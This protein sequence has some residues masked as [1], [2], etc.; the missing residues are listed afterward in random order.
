MKTIKAGE[1][2]YNT[3]GELP[4]S[5]LLRRYG[6]TAESYA[7]H[8]VVE[9]GSDVLVEI[10][11]NGLSEEEKDERV[12][13]HCFSQSGCY[14]ETNPGTAPQVEYLIDEAV[15][16]DAVDIPAS[17]HIPPE[18]LILLQTLTIPNPS[19]ISTKQRRS[20]RSIERT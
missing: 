13:S 7:T 14:R 12:T 19:L 11:G 3:Y 9:I 8:D 17:G 5:D 18:L 6:Y 16:E 10:A 20:Y 1:Q 4:R 2:L 15:L